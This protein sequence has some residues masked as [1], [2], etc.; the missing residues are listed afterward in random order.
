MNHVIEVLVWLTIGGI[1]GYVLGVART[2]MK[3]MEQ[4]S[5]ELHECHDVLHTDREG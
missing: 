3:Y 1:L 4:M 5:K 2:S